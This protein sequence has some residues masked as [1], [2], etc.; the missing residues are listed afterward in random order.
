MEAT[1]TDGNVAVRH[2]NEQIEKYWAGDLTR[3]VYVLRRQRKA[4][5]EN[6][7]RIAVVGVSADPE[8]P[9]FV[10]MER[11]LGMGLEMIPVV[12]GRE[13][14]VGIRC[15]ASLRDIPGKIDIVQIYP[16][17][18]IDLLPL[19][20]EAVEKRVA[21]FWIEV[22][23]LASPEVEDVLASGEVQLVEYEN[24]ESEYLKHAPPTAPAMRRD[25][26]GA[27]VFE[28]MTRNP[29]TVRAGDALKD[30]LAKME[31]GRFRHLPVVDEAGRLIA[32][33]SDRDI[34]LILP[35]LAFV[36]KEEAGFQVSSMAVQQ[37]AVYD[38]I[39]V[40]GDTSLKEAAGLMLRWQVG[41]LPVI[42]RQIRV[43]GIITYTDILR[44][45][46]NRN[47]AK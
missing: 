19:A 46:V 6:C 42:D 45:F 34:R 37:A 26:R 10:A 21:T 24:L 47:E 18:D 40:S 3:K 44:E 35:S 13:S 14:L 8:S 12:P 36:H 39:S 20:R 41:G 2:R 9:S 7:R 33:L 5:L 1:N 28:R 17:E 30:A 16:A 43:I 25:R 11:L 29:V 27:K 23:L 38:P 4:I 31:R 32:I 15:Y 22:G